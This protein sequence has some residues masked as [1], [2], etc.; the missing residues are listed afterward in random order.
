MVKLKVIA[1]DVLNREISYLASQSRCFVDV[2]FLRQ[3]LHCTPSKLAKAVQEEIDRANQGFPYNNYGGEP[4]YDYIVVGY[5][6]C[7]NGIVGISSEKIPLVIPKAH[8]CITLLL[9][10]RK[11]YKEWFDK[12]PGTYWFSRGWIER[13]AQPSEERYRALYDEYLAKYGK[14]DAEYLVSTEKGWLEDYS[15]AVFINW[16]FLGNSDYYRQFTERSAQYFN[17]SYTLVNGDFMLLNKILNGTFDQKEVLVVPPGKKVCP[18][19]GE[20]IIKFE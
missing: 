8:D 2:T 17:W 7:S 4:D 14:E 15:K 12:N 5:G 3:G 1:C 10:S 16:S 18:S 20:D 11:R 19:F 13:G 6:L 9:G